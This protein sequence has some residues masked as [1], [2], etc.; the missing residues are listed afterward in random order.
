MR[1]RNVICL[2]NN[3]LQRLPA[4]YRAATILEISA[5]VEYY[6]LAKVQRLFT[7]KFN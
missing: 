3:S 2:K 5:I 1:A 4:T 6:Y 7:R